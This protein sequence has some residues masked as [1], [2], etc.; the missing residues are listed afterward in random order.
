MTI[1]C[2]LCD[3]EMEIPDEWTEVLCSWC[4]TALIVYRDGSTNVSFPACWYDFGM[5]DKE[6]IRQLEAE[7]RRLTEQFKV[8][9]AAVM[10]AFADPTLKSDEVDTA[11]MLMII[12]DLGKRPRGE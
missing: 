1:R 10:K 7:N 11:M 6:R 12:E 3:N 2:V 9:K 4:L 5:T 8:L